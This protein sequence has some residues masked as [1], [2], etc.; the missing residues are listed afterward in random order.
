MRLDRQ[1]RFATGLALLPVV[2]IWLINGI[3][4][5]ALARVSVLLFWTADFLQWIVLPTI[6]LVSLKRRAAIFPRHYGLDTNFLRWQSPI[7][8]SL[9]VFITAGGASLLTRN[10]SWHLL[11]EPT[12]FFNFPG[13]LPG[14]PIGK[15]VWVYSAVTAGLVES[16]FFVGL[17]WLLYHN[18][19]NAPSR[20][21]FVLIVSIV[22]AAA[23]WEQGLHVV[24]AAFAFNLVACAWYFKLG[25][26][27]PVVA[28]HTLVDL[29]TFS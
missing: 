1:Q 29:A 24:A 2:A 7:L 4:L 28:G 6:L 12:G 23:H 20:R 14:G 19:R 8:G 3:Y 21:F 13:V 16:I 18:I 27:W 25:T 11:G 17:P 15:C 26:L 9:G 10:V 22:F 5:A